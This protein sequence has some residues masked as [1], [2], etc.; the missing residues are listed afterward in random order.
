MIYNSVI[1]HKI[2]G[3]IN[4]TGKVVKCIKLVKTPITGA[5]INPD[6][7]SPTSYL[8]GDDGVTETETFRTIKASV[9]YTKWEQIDVTTGFPIPKGTMTLSCKVADEGAVDEAD[10][11]EVDGNRMYVLGDKKYG[12]GGKTYKKYILLKQGTKLKYEDKA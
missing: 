7:G 4:N 10:Y 8:Y 5:V 6:T 3:I 9:S 11:I 12:F 1:K 2:D